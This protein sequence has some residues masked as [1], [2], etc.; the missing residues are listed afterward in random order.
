MPDEGGSARAPAG[1]GISSAFRNCVEGA[2]LFYLAHLADEAFP[3]PAIELSIVHAKAANTSFPGVPT[4]FNAELRFDDRDSRKKSSELRL[5]VSSAAVAY[6]CPAI[7]P[8]ILMHELLC[9]WPQFAGLDRARS[10]PQEVA[11]LFDHDASSFEC[12]PFA[13][14]WMDSLVSEVLGWRPEEGRAPYMAESEIET[15]KLIHGLRTQYITRPFFQ[16]AVRI[17][18]S[19]IASRCVRELYATDPSAD[20]ATGGRDFARLS[21]EMNVAPWNYRERARGCH[22]IA[23]ACDAYRDAGQKLRLLEATS[24]CIVEALLGFRQSRD[25]Y[26]LMHA[27]ASR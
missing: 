17:A 18:G 24:A 12:D 9:H 23:E 20:R 11:S 3:L 25:I 10:N 26:P 5:K 2:R 15:A 8:Y 4:A 19:A 14:G 7:L 27:L 6:G 22:L 1:C 13:E 16:D 21:C